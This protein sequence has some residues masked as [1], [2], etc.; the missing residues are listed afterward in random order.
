MC[1]DSCTGAVSCEL[2]VIL[3]TAAAAADLSF[4]FFVFFFSVLVRDNPAVFS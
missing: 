1:R 2:S 4:V 3:P